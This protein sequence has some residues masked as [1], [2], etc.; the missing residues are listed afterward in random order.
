MLITQDGKLS[1]HL[2]HL[3]RC[4]GNATL[5]AH[6]NSLLGVVVVAGMQV[7]RL[8]SC[9]DFGLIP[10]MVCLIHMDKDTLLT[11]HMKA[12]SSAVTVG[13]V[14]AAGAVSDIASGAAGRSVYLRAGA[15]TFSPSPPPPLAALFS[16]ARRANRD[17]S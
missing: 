2:R 17:F 15:L 5:T 13:S 4:L 7:P 6:P 12:P 16:S 9:G 8:S 14:L 10:A 1:C 11:T 3:H